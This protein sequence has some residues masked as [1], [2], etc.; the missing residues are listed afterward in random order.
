MFFDFLMFGMI[1]ALYAVWGVDMVSTFYENQV[2]AD[3]ALQKGLMI[4]KHNF[5]LKAY[6]RT[7]SFKNVHITNRICFNGYCKES[8][9]DINLNVHEKYTSKI[10][11]TFF[12]IPKLPPGIYTYKITTDAEGYEVL[13]S[14]KLC[15]FSIK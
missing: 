2:Y 8:Y 7:E 4:G 15:S 3:C 9:Q 6:D 13:H 12:Q 10:N 5:I 1:G 14:E 11:Y